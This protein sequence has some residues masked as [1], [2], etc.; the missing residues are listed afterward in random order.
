MSARSPVRNVS[1]YALVRGLLAF[2]LSVGLEHALRI[3]RAVGD[4]LFLLD[5]KH[6]TRALRNLG[7]AFPD[8]PEEGR[9]RIAR[10]AFRS[11]VLTIVEMAY[12]PRVLTRGSFT[13]HVHFRIHPEARAAI[14]GGGVVIFTA[15]IGNW[16]LSGLASGMMGLPFTSVARPLDNPFLN[17]FVVRT[18][19][20]SGQR[21]IFKR[22]ALREMVRAV[23]SGGVLAVISDQ[24][25]GRHGVLVDFFGRPASATAAPATVALRQGVPLL[26]GWQRRVGPGF[27]HVLTIEAPLTPPATGDRE[28]DVH[29][30]TQAMAQRMEEWIRRE[31]GQWLWAH[32][33]WKIRGP[34]KEEEEPCRP[35]PSTSAV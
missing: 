3:G 10:D 32:R 21:I 8:L 19:E 5:R 7:N 25:A 14:D 22:G 24:N 27:R 18:R 16:E 28:R 9:T 6:R 11:V 30:M 23:K 29:E 1:E 2:V 20:R 33:R 35:S 26:P 31:P 12:L 4:L 13:R 15:H 17:G 34:K